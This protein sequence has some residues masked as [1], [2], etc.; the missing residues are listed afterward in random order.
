MKDILK[1]IIFAVVD[2]AIV[3]L[4]LTFFKKNLT[5]SI[6]IIVLA[7]IAFITYIVILIIKH[8]EAEK[9]KKEIKKP[10]QKPKLFTK[11]VTKPKIKKPILQKKPKPIRK[12]LA[13][14]QPKMTDKIMNIQEL[15]KYIKTNLKEG[16]SKEKIKQKVISFGWPQNE[17]EKIF[18]ELS[19]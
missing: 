4:A 3:I 5:I 17:V 19:K 15:K 7:Q 13:K 16:F 14:P 6:I 11:A 1:A 18:Q 2:L 8:K 10:I 12:P 9:L